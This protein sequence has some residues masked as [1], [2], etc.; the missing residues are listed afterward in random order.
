MPI[1][2]RCWADIGKSMMVLTMSFFNR[3][4]NLNKNGLQKQL[5]SVI[6]QNQHFVNITVIVACLQATADRYWADM[7][8]FIMCVTLRIFDRN[9]MIN[10]KV[11]R[12]KSNKNQF[13]YNYIVCQNCLLYRPAGGPLAARDMRYSALKPMSA[14]LLNVCWVTAYWFL[15]VIF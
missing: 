11:P 14:R 3:I 6:L 8:K 5:V 10:N 1:S 13:C 4:K 2:A 12:K 7:V 9:V 15:N